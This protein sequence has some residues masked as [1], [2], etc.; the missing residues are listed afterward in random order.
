MIKYKV[1]SIDSFNAKKFLSCTRYGLPSDLIV[2]YHID[3]WVEAPVGGLLV[4]NNKNLARSFAYD[5]DGVQHYDV[6]TCKVEE[7]VKLPECN[8]FPTIDQ[9]FE[10]FVKLWNGQEI[11]ELRSRW[12][13]G[14]EAYRKVKLIEKISI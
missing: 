4:F 6:F 8:I 1:I 12:P 14:T 5:S 11:S 7:P 10:S 3:K 2:E 13:L 9:A